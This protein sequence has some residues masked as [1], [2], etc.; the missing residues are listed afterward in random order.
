MR[1]PC[2]DLENEGR[3][4]PHGLKAVE[5]KQRIAELLTLAACD[6]EDAAIAQR[7][8][9]GRHSSAY[10]VAR[11][12]AEVVMVAEGYRPRGGEDQHGGV[13]GGALRHDPAPAL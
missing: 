6:L 9:D 2:S 7:P 1:M 12:V 10:E 8:A 11:A 4:R 5:G 13:S 3:L